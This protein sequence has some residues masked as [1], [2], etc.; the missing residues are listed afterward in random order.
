M[1]VFKKSL[2]TVAVAAGLGLS[3]LA[4]AGLEANIGATSNYIWRGV[5]Q[6]GGDAAISGGVDW[7]HDSGVYLG[8]WTSSL[9]GGQYELDLYGGY[10]MEIGGF[11]MDFGVISYEYPVEPDGYFREV[12]FNGSW[13]V[14]SFGAAYTFDSDDDST[15]EF[16]KG[17]LY[18]SLGADFDF[19]NDWSAGVYGG[20]YDFDDSDGEDYSHYG[21]KVGKAAGDYGDFTLAIDKND[22]DAEGA[23]DPRVS[24][25]WAKTF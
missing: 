3:A 10:G 6:A 5:E 9:G 25:S 12:Y 7:S 23:D 14:L 19:G 18:L 8:T 22:L 2:L 16:S 15:P 13:S 21:A 11:G 1:S 17:D 4:Q 24:V 20:D